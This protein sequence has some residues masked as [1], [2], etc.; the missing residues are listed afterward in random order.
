MSNEFFEF[1]EDNVIN[2]SFF[3]AIRICMMRNFV[4]NVGKNKGVKNDN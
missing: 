2:V 3:F 1:N 4:T